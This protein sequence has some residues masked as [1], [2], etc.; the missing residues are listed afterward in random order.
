M[1]FNGNHIIVFATSDQGGKRYFHCTPL[2]FTAPAGPLSL[3]MSYSVHFARREGF[4]PRKH[5]GDATGDC[6]ELER[7]MY[8]NK[9]GRKEREY[10]VRNER[11]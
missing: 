10:E 9:M 6:F 7:G 2:G 3:A 4:I 11:R 1:I 5:Q 8:V